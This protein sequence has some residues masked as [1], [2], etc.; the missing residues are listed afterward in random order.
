MS[1]TLEPDAPTRAVDRG[2]YLLATL[3]VALGGYTVYDAT[4]LNVG[5]G[6]PVGP[7]AFPYVVGSVLLVLGILL[8]VATARGDRP[9]AEE[10]EDVDLTHPADWATLAKLVV[11]L[12]FTAATLGVLG[13]A[14]NGAIL[15]AGSAWALGSRTLVRD[16]LIGI[17]LSV[18]SWYAFYVGLGIPL[19]PGILD[20]IL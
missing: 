15:F 6:D 9:Q 13:W 18:G 2:Q 4:T 12:V 11:V 14:I 16:I 10:G 20:G 3:L 1:T 8:A 19:S 5:F 17:V 7:R